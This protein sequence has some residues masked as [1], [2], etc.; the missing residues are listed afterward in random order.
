MDLDN[1]ELVATKKMNN[2]NKNYSLEEIEIILMTIL[3]NCKDTEELQTLYIKVSNKLD[4]VTQ[5]RQ[6]EIERRI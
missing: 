1:S 4:E 2:C 6:Q 5:K 3:S